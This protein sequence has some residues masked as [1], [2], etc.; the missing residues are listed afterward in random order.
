M[1]TSAMV[2]ALFPND[3]KEG[4]LSAVR[5]EARKAGI[6]PSREAIWQ[7]SVTKCANNAMTPVWVIF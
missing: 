7:Y 3:E 6:S 5:D 4:I 2:P 1:L